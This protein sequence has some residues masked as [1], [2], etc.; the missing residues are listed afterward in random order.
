[1]SILSLDPR[2]L[3]DGT[4]AFGKKSKSVVSELNEK[5]LGDAQKCLQ[6]FE[7]EATQISS[8]AELS[9]VAGVHR[10]SDLSLTL[11][12]PASLSFDCGRV[13]TERNDLSM[14]SVA[15]HSARC[16]EVLRYSVMGKLAQENRR[17]SGHLENK[18]NKG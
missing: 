16:E 8:I 17:M 13:L 4:P 7:A 5:E 14:D 6:N 9:S 18:E 2:A 1:M 3:E 11:R 15:P 10:N 12:T